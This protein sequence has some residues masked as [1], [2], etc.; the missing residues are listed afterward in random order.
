[1]KASV[2]VQS[3]GR[4]EAR[5]EGRKGSGGDGEGRDGRWGRAEVHRCGKAR[6]GGRQVLSVQEG[7]GGGDGWVGIGASL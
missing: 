3:G 6:V 4:Q 5:E 1:M 7:K 2:C